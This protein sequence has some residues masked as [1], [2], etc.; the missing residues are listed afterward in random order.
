[1][2][3]AAAAASNSASEATSVTV[4]PFSWPISGGHQ[5]AFGMPGDLLC[6]LAGQNGSNQLDAGAEHQRLTIGPI[7]VNPIRQA[8]G[9]RRLQTAPPQPPGL[10]DLA[11]PQ[12]SASSALHRHQHKHGSVL[13]SLLHCIRSDALVSLCLSSAYSVVPILYQEIHTLQPRNRRKLRGYRISD[14]GYR[15]S[16]CGL[17]KPHGRAEGSKVIRSAGATDG[18]GLRGLGASSRVVR[19]FRG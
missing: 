15:M 5:R 9:P 16:D 6:G 12:A 17:R 11:D 2:P 14:I 8:P 3:S 18:A 7:A 13:W 4:S 1:M 19:V 10:A